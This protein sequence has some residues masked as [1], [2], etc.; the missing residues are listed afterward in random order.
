MTAC[1]PR[2]ETRGLVALLHFEIQKPSCFAEWTADTRFITL[3]RHV[4]V[5]NKRTSPGVSESSQRV[6]QKWRIIFL[7]L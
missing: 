3:S 1:C 4:Y 5:S 6:A 2:R 7:S